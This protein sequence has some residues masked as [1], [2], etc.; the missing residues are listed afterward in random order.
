VASRAKFVT[1]SVDACKRKSTCGC[2]LPLNNHNLNIL[3][4]SVDIPV[5]LC[6]FNIKMKTLCVRTKTT[7]FFLCVVC[8]VRKHALSFIF[9]MQL[10][11]TSTQRGVIYVN[12]TRYWNDSLEF[13]RAF[14]SSLKL[15]EDKQHFT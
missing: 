9:A 3:F 6:G 12:E 8:N 1:V 11:I 15:D 10:V 4:V 5:D 13:I 14:L 7:S 2:S